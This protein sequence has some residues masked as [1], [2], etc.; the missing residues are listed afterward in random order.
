MA[1]S[2]NGDPALPGRIAM[3]C[4]GGGI[5]GGVFEVGVLRALDQ[6]LGGGVVNNCQMYAG[7]SAGALLSTMLA[8]GVTPQ[9]MDHVI[10]RGARNRRNLPPLKRTS[11]YGLDLVPWASAAVRFPVRMGMGFARS[12]LPG[13]SSRPAD[14]VFEALRVSP[15]GIFSNRP[16]GEYVKSALKAVRYEDSFRAFSSELFIPA[17]NLDTGHKV[18]FGEQGA[19]DVPVS[20]AIRAS[21]AVPLL[22]QPV[23][24]AHQDFVDGGIERNLP[25]DVVVRHGASLVI[26]INPMVPI[27]NDPGTEGSFNRGYSYLADQGM[28]SVADQMLRLMIRSQVVYGLQQLRDQYPEVDI[29]LFEPEASDQMVFNYHLMRYSSRQ[30][31]AQ[32]AYESTKERIIREADKLAPIFRRHGLELDPEKL[33]PRRS[34]NRKDS[35]TRRVARRLENLPLIR[36]VVGQHDTELPF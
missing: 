26:A 4:G 10:V 11:V 17:I 22:F 7:A 27:V 15:P 20:L 35:L 18:V 31:I 28:G 2:Q 25:V 36:D 14:A 29:V 6:A 5:V 24:I 3:V 30:Q 1:S 12:L 33:G 19:Q 21:A 32:H 23:R 13:E 16:L 8:S 9:E 34:K